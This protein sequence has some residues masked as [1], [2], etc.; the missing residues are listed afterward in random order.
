MSILK[1]FKE[2]ILKILENYFDNIGE[3]NIP[4]LQIGFQNVLILDNI[5]LKEDLLIKNNIPFTISKSNIG[6]VTINIPMNILDKEVKIFMENME[7]YLSGFDYHMFQDRPNK[8]NIK[9]KKGKIKQL[10][11]QY[12]KIFEDMQYSWNMHKIFSNINVSISNV[13]INFISDVIA[14]HQSRFYV[15]AENIEIKQTIDTDKNA[16]LKKIVFQKLS[17]GLDSSKFQNT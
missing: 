3:K 6:R 14:M 4:K 16:H 7:I 12:R 2:K 5:Q 15:R 8:N 11:D 9:N 13:N 1:I 10:E 17:L